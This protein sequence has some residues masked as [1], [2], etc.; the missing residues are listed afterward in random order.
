MGPPCPT[1][2]QVLKFGGTSIV[3]TRTHG[4]KKTSVT[5]GL[6]HQSCD[7]PR[8]NVRN[9]NNEKAYSSVLHVLTKQTR[10]AILI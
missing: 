7:P 8:G 5:A 2:M 3:I 6:R 10:E 9:R 4:G 1:A